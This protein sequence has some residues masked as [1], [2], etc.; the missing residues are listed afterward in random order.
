MISAIVFGVALLG[1]AVAPA[2]VADQTPP[3]FPVARCE[4]EFKPVARRA[5]FEAK[6][7]YRLVTGSDGVV[8]SVEEEESGS[9]AASFRPVFESLAR[10]VK[11]WVLEPG[12]AYTAELHWGSSG[13]EPTWHV[14]RTA[15]GCIVLSER[16]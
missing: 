6:V 10:C 7:L 13:R 5:Y 14:C 15:G 4:L 8:A 12:T 3:V 9:S 11:T 16:R 2:A 1:P